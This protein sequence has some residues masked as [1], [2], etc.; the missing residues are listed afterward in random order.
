MPFVARHT[1]TDKLDFAERASPD[2]NYRCF[3]CEQ[4]V[5]YVNEYLRGDDNTR[6][7]S[8]FRYNNCSHAGVKDISEHSGGGESLKHE[9]RK[10]A[11]MHEAANRYP[12]GIV[13]S[14]YTIGEKRADAVLIFDEPHEK[15]GKGL[16]IEYQYKNENKDLQ[17]TQEHYAEHEFTTLWITDRE[18]T[19]QGNIPDIDLFGGAVYS[20]WPNSVPE[21]KEWQ[22]TVFRR[23]HKF[24]TVINETNA[25]APAKF[26]MDWFLPTTANYWDAEQNWD[27]RF[28]YAGGYES[29]RYIIQA[30]ADSPSKHR[31]VDP[32][33]Q[34]DWVWPTEQDY[35]QSESID[36]DHRFSG[37][38]PYYPINT[39][40]FE[41]QL[42]IPVSYWMQDPPEDIIKKLRKDHKFGVQ[43]MLNNGKIP[44]NCENCDNRR[45]LINTAPT[46][47][48]QCANCNNWNL[49]RNKGG[50]NT[51][52]VPKE[53][54]EV[55]Q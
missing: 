12:D 16:A 42:D 9:R 18:F 13:K 32:K 27:A 11:A 1:G 35:W 26:I 49:V 17:A 30:L 39:D 20:V 21:K 3:M 19:M 46:H 40:S 50:Y 51:N 2:G 55:H 15:Y 4:P 31:T 48:W 43:I 5:S 36:W 6:V 25:K 22:K 52:V 41:L 29:Q 28:R 33:I 7:Q 38:N 34:L 44:V 24:H 54:Q 23:K 53:V 10:L 14:E 47:G 45:V 8:H 37:T